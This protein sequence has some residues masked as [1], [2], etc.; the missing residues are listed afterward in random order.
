MYFFGAQKGKDRSASGADLG[1]SGCIIDHP[2]LRTIRDHRSDFSSVPALRT[3]MTASSLDTRHP[4]FPHSPLSSNGFQSTRGDSWS[5]GKIRHN[6]IVIL[7]KEQMIC[8]QAK[9]STASSSTIEEIRSVVDLGRWKRKRG[10]CPCPA[11]SC[12]NPRKVLI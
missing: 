2:F 4:V 11:G 6:G 9:R 5:S 12:K 3:L 8:A 1:F 7:N 10:I